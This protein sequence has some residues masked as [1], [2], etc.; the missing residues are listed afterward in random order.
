MTIGR[1]ADA[2]DVSVDTVR[3][4]ER[5]GLLA[6]PPRTAG[7]FR[8]YDADA[9][10][11]LR[12]LRRAQALGFTLDEAADLLALSRDEHADAE[13]VRERTV[14]KIADLDARI[15]ELEKT[16]DALAEL[17]D[18]CGGRHDTRA[19]CPVLRALAVPDP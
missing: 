11:R 8:D 1:L 9:V 17:A 13:A 10:R 4:Y 7:G 6:E 3:Y 15:A 5:R 16:R 18:A 2:A 14:E 12:A 19:E